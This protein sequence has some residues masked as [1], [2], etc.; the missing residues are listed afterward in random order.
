MII[1]ADRAFI[2][3]LPQVG[4]VRRGQLS[5]RNP[6]KTMDINSGLVDEVNYTKGHELIAAFHPASDVIVARHRTPSAFRERTEEQI[7]P[8]PISKHLANPVSTSSS[9][10]RNTKLSYALS[11]TLFSSPVPSFSL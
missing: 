7:A 6:P 3:I 10:F 8:D 4:I 2:Q 11:L 1:R 9:Y 5:R